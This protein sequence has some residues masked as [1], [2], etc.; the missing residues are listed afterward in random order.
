MNSENLS[1]TRKF[2]C[3]RGTCINVADPDRARNFKTRVIKFYHLYGTVP[4]TLKLT[5]T[6]K[7]M[8]K[9]VLSTH[10]NFSLPT[11]LFTSP[12]NPLNSRSLNIL[13]KYQPTTNYE[14]LRFRL[15]TVP[16]VIKMYWIISSFTFYTHV[17]PSSYQCS[18]WFI[19]SNMIKNVNDSPIGI[20]TIN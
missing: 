17:F 1:Y 4:H 12:V 19:I 5:F 14:I 13:E 9:L 2:M 20:N 15:L 18:V 10:L 7:F 16:I 3:L 6:F 11:I 8:H